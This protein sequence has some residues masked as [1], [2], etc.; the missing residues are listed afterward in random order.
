[1]KYRIIKDILSRFGELVPAG[2]IHN[3]NGVL[4]YLHVGR[5]FHDRKL[6][7]PQRSKNYDEFYRKTCHSLSE[8]V[9]FL[10]FGVF[11]GDSLL[12]WTGL[13][14]D[15]A[16]ELHGFDSF[17]GLPE[18]W[19]LAVKKGHFDLSG[20]LPQFY[21]TRVRLH[22]GWFSETLPKFLAE[23]PLSTNLVIHLDADLYSSTAFVLNALRASIR[24]GAIL[25][26]DEFWDRE[27]ELKAF[28]EFLIDTGMLVEC[29][30]V[31]EGLRQASFKVIAGV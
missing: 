16:T 19:G 24:P 7:I 21:D 30:A 22:K 31:T 14:K 10:E 28:S 23:R 26:F 25:I 3:A 4:N 27:H 8:P 1:M 15:T 17:E 29:L 13:L 11:K 20:I 6:C 2:W 12:H 9:C 5:W 18:S